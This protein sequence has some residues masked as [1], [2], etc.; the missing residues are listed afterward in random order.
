MEQDNPVVNSLW[1]GSKLSLM[2]MLTIKSFIA[3]GHVF[4]LWTYSEPETKLP[5][6]V[7]VMDANEILPQDK[8]FRYKSPN[9][10]GHGMGSV[11]GFSDI[12]RYKLLYEKGGWWVD[13]DVTCIKYLNFDEEFVF[14]PHHELRVVGNVM[15]APKGNELMKLCFEQAIEEV[16]E[17]NTDWHKPIQILNHHI[18][19]LGLEQ[20]IQPNFSNEDKWDEVKTYLTSNTSLPDNYLCLHWMNEEWRRRQ[21]DKYDFMIDSTYGSLLIRYGLI[22]DDFN[23][24]NRQKNFIRH[25]FLNLFSN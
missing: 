5:A 15:K 2:E 1:I 4:R 8:I 10:F 19:A 22:A 3:C 14:R 16:N 12:F 20:Y 6:G 7:L 11:S 13:M 24:F 23:W 9:Q 21:I 17:E 25:R 18:Q